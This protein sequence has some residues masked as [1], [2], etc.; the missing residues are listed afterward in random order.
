M[1]RRPI[2]LKGQRRSLKNLFTTKLHLTTTITTEKLMG[3][4]M[5]LMRIPLLTMSKAQMYSCEQKKRSRPLF[6]PYTLRKSLVIRQQKKAD[7]GTILGRGWRRYVL[8][9]VIRETDIRDVLKGF[10]QVLFV[11]G[12]R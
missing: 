4:A 5:T 10:C 7:S 3:R 8:L 2:S 9:G 1:G 12:R 11:D 6:K